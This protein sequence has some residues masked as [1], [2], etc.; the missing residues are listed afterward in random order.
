M[1]YKKGPYSISTDTS[2][3]DLKV[4]HGYLSRSYWAEGIPVEIIKK[5]I[6]GSMCFGVY[7]GVKQ[8][9]FAR[10]VTDNATFAYLCD[11]FILEEYR[12]QGL[13]VWLMEIITSH[14]EL[15]GFRRWMLGTRDAHGLYK[16][17]GFVE[18]SNPER[19]MQIHNPDVYKG[20]QVQ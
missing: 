14:P 5:S 10:V 13:S 3:L 9:G 11:V 6:E 12:G 19:F 4:I 7:D 17:F 1:I 18:L 15:S 16:K 20:S 8:I 2:R